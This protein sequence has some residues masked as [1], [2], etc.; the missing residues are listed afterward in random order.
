MLARYATLTEAEIGTLVIEDK[1][2]AR[3]RDAIRGEVERLIGRL[4]ARIMVLED[5]YARPLPA[6]EREVEAFGAKVE[7]HLRRMGF[8]P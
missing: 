8:A 2:F 3:L 7:A 4:T 5:R 1:W 6:L